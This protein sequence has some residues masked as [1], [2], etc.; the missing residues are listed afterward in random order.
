MPS[1]TSPRGKTWPPAIGIRS[2]TAM[3]EAGKTS[4][5]V[6]PPLILPRA[7]GRRLL[8]KLSA[9]GG[10]GD[11]YLASTTGL[12]GAERPCIVKTV[13]RD[14]VHDPSF[15]AR[16]LDEARVQ[17]Q[18]Q[19]PGV[20]QVL[21]A[22]T[23]ESGEPYTVVEYVEGRS[24]GEARLRAIQVGVKI[25][26]PE[27][28]AM[29]LEIAQALAHVHERSG[30]D[31]AP[32]GIV[33]RDLSPQNV[34]IGHGGEVKLIDFGTARGHNRRCH[35][36]AGVV[37]AKPGYVAPEVARQQV[38]DGR[39]DLYALGVVLWEL[40]AGR[41]LLNTDPQRHLDDVA[42]GRVILPPV[43]ESCGAPR[44]L[45]GVIA[46]LTKS[47]P[48]ERYPRAS[49]TTG[50]LASLLATAPSLDG[51]ERGVRARI[52]HLM[53][54][55]WPHEPARSR[56]EFARLLRE[57]RASWP[58]DRARAES[59]SKEGTLAA[60]ASVDPAKPKSPTLQAHA[61]PASLLHGTPYRL[62]RVLGR[63]TGGVVWEAEHVELGRRLALKIL[64]PE[65]ASS[66]AALERF[67]REARAVAKL[68]HPNLVRVLDFGKSLDGRV[69]L[70]MDLLVGESLDA[71]LRRG[72]IAWSE[73]ARIASA[74]CGALAAAH[75]T[76]LIHRDIKPQN[77]MTTPAGEVKLLDFG[78]ARAAADAP[79]VRAAD[80]KERVLRGFAILGT[81]EYMA[82]EQVAGGAIDG[83][84]DVYALGCVL[85]ELLTGAPPFQ[86]SSVVV[87]GKQLRE[88]PA[89]PRARAPERA[90]PI[91]IDEAVGRAMAK[92]PRHRFP[93]AVEMAAA[94]ER[95]IGAPA[96]RRTTARRIA[97]WALVATGALAAAVASAQVTRQWSD[98]NVAPVAAPEVT[99]RA[100]A[101][102]LQPERAPVETRPLE[103]TGDLAK[104]RTKARHRAGTGANG[105]G[106]AGE[107]PSSE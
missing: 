82:P 94:L 81:P 61:D 78:I 1:R 62:V 6:A 22:A 31:G 16:F 55:L 83:R 34:M 32:L 73:A 35:T 3:G 77:V 11:V 41:R 25:A 103:G 64:A 69:F 15:L 56:A 53:K 36:V 96:R 49:H 84:S 52:A 68:S 87:M 79:D 99:Q 28:V 21:D 51:G 40:C 10:M 76:G 14:H 100:S 72:P 86:G 65:H 44:E 42:A 2:V 54:R 13:R 75:A 38:G 88:T 45:D 85:Y 12:E 18:L 23:D 98:A 105:G 106:G 26:W 17:A 102:P 50:D 70:T 95:A 107:H 7:I 9:R 20:A 46:K 97:R 39:I 47:D 63:G 60:P 59:P 30:P 27:A 101:A 93:S 74:V 48:D 92:D 71:T 29:A 37:F 19:H 104:A 43:A 67:R 4:P 91:A 24:L 66:P 80:P 57:A 58:D 5:S 89:S 90:I 33:H 8:L